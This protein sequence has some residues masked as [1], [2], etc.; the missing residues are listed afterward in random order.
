[1]RKDIIYRQDAID[2]ICD[3]GC[4]SKYCGI[5]CPSIIRIEKLP[6]VQSEPKIGEWIFVHPL[7]KDNS[8]AYM[9][10]CCKNGDWDIKLTD[11]FCKFCGAMMLRKGE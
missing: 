1:M 7:Q 4:N 8:G 11:R 2:A 6:S 10:S 5:S 3:E 9:C